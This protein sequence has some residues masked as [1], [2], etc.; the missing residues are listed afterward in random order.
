MRYVIITEDGTTY[1]SDA[2]DDDVKEAC[3]MGIMDAIDTQAV[4]MVTYLAGEWH[5]VMTWGKE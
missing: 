2:V 4:P 5:E 1:Q 3:D